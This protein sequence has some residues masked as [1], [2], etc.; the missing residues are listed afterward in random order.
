QH[1]VEDDEIGRLER[2]GGERL[3][4]VRGRVD[5]VA[6]LGERDLQ[7][8]PD[9]SLVVDHEDALVAAHRASPSGVGAAGIETVS[10][11]P[12]P[13]AGWRV[14]VAP[15]AAAS[16]WAMARPRPDPGAVPLRPR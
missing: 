2:R 10:V 16:P 14:T 7:R 6:R 3:V 5:V 9:G 11:V 8:A 1:Q 4:A 15:F 12:A 13:F